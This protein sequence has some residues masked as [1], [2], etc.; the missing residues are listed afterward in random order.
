M[1]KIIPY[2][3]AAAVEYA[4]RWAYSRN[5]AYYSYDL[6]GG[7]C[8]NFSSQCLFA[9]AG[10]MDHTPTLGWYYYSGDK[11][12]P[13]WTGVPYFYNFI[14]RRQL[15]SGPFGEETGISLIRPGDFAQLRFGGGAFSHCPIVVSVGNPPSPENILVAAHSEDA[16]YRPLDTYPARQVRFLHILGVRQPG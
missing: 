2:D 15:T 13:A 9:G 4:H 16:D 3:R 8:T 5:P 11:K 12:A 14:T 10:V 1:P 7:D 6:L